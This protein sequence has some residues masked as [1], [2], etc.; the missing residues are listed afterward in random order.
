MAMMLGAIPTTSKPAFLAESKKPAG[1]IRRA[2]PLD[3]A[4]GLDAK[5]ACDREGLSGDIVG[6]VGGQEDG[7]IAD[8]I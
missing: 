4:V 3:E 7:R 2:F 1:A 5:S 8:V 6:V